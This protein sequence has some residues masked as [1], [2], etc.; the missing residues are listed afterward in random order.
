M[1]TKSVNTIFII[2]GLVIAATVVYFIV[3][4]KESSQDFINKDTAPSFKKEGELIFINKAE[5]DTLA[6]ID[7]EIADN[8][9]KTS[10]GLMY[11]SSMPENAGMLFFMD[12]QRIQGFWMK[13]TYIPLDMIFVN[14]E[15]EVVTIHANTTPMKE[16]SYFST[17]PALYVV[18][19]N[20]GFCRKN[21]IQVGDKIKFSINR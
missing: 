9:Q 13:N 16:S 15:M 5:G 11:R 8:D 7:I 12:S 2:V 18:E 17:A 4:N 21:N 6:V 3:N 1:K 10:Q 14:S 19:V 20:A